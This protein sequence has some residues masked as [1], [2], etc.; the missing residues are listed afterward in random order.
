MPVRILLLEDSPLDAE[1]IGEHLLR[2]PV[3]CAVE[4][5][6]TRAE[7]RAALVRGQ[8][9]L[10]LSDYA[11][12]AFDGMAALD[13]AREQAPDTPF[14]FISGM[15]GEETATETLK[16]GATDYVLKQRMNRLPAAIQRAMKE[17]G[18][19]R[20]RRR[21]EERTRLLVAELSHRVKNTLAT[22]V[23]IA[24]Q[25]F[26]KT[27]DIDE[28][29]A[30]F[31]G[32]IEALADAHGLLFQANWCDLELTDVLD[33]ALRPFRRGDG[34]TI[35]LEGGPIHLPPTQALTLNLIVHELA[36]NAAKY[37]ALSRE[38]GEVRVTWTVDGVDG[39][40]RLKLKWE[41]AG[42]PPVSPPKRRGFGSTL[43]ERSLTYEFDGAAELLFRPEGLVCRLSLP[44]TA[45]VSQVPSI[46]RA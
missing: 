2:G 29:R 26:Q 20:E 8:Y 9:D 10:I 12:P 31:M 33:A 42:G 35:H 6:A 22:V 28:F 34:K 30:A 19:R 37:G 7:Y 38:G 3:Y 18:E 16:R 14:I 39:E 45:S 46:S 23:A 43:I 15:F 32:R 24:Q 36:T 17:A 41:E 25:T 13:M 1:L 40:R 27:A 4:R 44:L 11:M 21:A 5:V